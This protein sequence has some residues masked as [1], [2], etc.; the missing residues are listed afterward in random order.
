MLI[1]KIFV[2]YVAVLCCS[3]WQGQSIDGFIKL[4]VIFIRIILKLVRRAV[5]CFKLSKIVDTIVSAV[6]KL[7]IGHSLQVWLSVYLRAVI[8]VDFFVV[9]KRPRGLGLIKLATLATDITLCR[10]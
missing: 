9:F 3:S 1:K 10:M 6:H 2:T 4:S 8:C 5:H 7:S